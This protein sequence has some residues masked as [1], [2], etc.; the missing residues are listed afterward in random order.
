MMLDGS[1]LLSCT[2][3]GSLRLWDIKN[4]ANKANLL[5]AMNVDVGV[6]NVVISLDT[7]WEK[8]VVGFWNGDVTIIDY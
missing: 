8:V 6:N 4:N 1:K 3:A 5:T 2:C 7:S